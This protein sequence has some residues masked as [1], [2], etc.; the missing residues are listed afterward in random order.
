MFDKPPG[1]EVVS[2]QEWEEDDQRWTIEDAGLDA[3]WD[4]L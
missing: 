3:L 1:T 2:F 4:I